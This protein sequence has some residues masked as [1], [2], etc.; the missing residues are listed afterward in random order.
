MKNNKVS[1]QELKKKKKKIISGNYSLQKKE[2]IMNEIIQFRN[3]ENIAHEMV[4]MR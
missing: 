4:I 3:K 1:F 2:L